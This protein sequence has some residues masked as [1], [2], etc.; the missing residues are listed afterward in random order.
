MTCWNALKHG[1]AHRLRTP[2]V[3]GSLVLAIH[4]S[5]QSTAPSPTGV[6]RLSWLVGCWVEDLGPLKIEDR[7]TAPVGRTMLGTSR[8]LRGDTTIALEVRTITDSAGRLVL[9]TTSTAARASLIGDSF[10]ATLAQ[11]IDPAGVYPRVVSYRREGPDQL[12]IRREGERGGKR[13][14]IDH[15]FDRAPCARGSG[16]ATQRAVWRP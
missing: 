8:T 14:Q 6:A 11:F 13:R 12:V 16:D 5:T 4:L 3:L 9:T 10:T 15:L 1:V 7:W 2:T